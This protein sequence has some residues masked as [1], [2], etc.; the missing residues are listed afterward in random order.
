MRPIN[1]S[2]HLPALSGGGAGNP[3]ITA[4]QCQPPGASGC[5]WT[6][7]T[8]LCLSSGTRIPPGA[9]VSNTAFPRSCPSARKAF[10]SSLSGFSTM[11][12]ELTTFILLQCR[13]KAGRQ[14][15][16][17]QGRE[18][19]LPPEGG[20]RQRSS[21]RSEKKCTLFLLLPGH[22]ASRSRPHG[23]WVGSLFARPPAAGF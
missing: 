23:G 17:P 16:S 5:R 20:P 3:V 21:L 18:P 14:P 10:L 2:G 6:M 7:M 8:S 4:A 22:V 9:T 13:E 12:G 15:P 19:P 11:E 1:A